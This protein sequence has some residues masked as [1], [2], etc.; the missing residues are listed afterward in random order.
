MT[1]WQWYSLIFVITC[2]MAMGV[3]DAIAICYGGR[4]ATISYLFTMLAYYWPLG[5]FILGAVVGHLFWPQCS[6]QDDALPERR[7]EVRIDDKG[8]VLGTT[9]RIVENH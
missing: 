1:R 6:Y 9:E 2:F 5:V 3:W 8:N 4:K 7:I